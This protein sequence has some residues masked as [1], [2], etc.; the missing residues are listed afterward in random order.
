M[1]D[2]SQ[3]EALDP[4]REAEPPQPADSA[5]ETPSSPADTVD[6]VRR[7]CDE[8]RDLLMRTTAEF[9]NYRKRIERERAE[10]AQAV[11]I[12]LITELLPL[13]DDLE[14]A[15]AVDAS[16]DAVRAY[17]EGVE[18]IHKQLL[19]LLSKRGVT[20]IEADGQD[21]DP[22]YHQA[23]SHEVSEDHREGM[24]IGELRRGYMLGGRLLRPAMVRVAKA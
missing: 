3:P 12:D 10:V 9:D 20:P 24:V 19:D 4:H 6:E 5:A 2:D 18:L 16:D 7:Q 23:V 15:L 21:F 22:N 1:K 13:V 17:R 8:Y 14:R 11:G